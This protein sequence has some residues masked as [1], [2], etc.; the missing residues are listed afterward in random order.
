MDVPIA[1]KKCATCRWWSGSR[2]IRFVGANPEYVTIKG[3]LPGANC[4]AWPDKR[5]FS[6]TATCFRWSKWEKL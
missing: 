2:S 4:R 5:P 6:G 3:G 1:H